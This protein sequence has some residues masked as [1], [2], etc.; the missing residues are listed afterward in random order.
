MD[1][2]NKA[3]PEAKPRLA[4]LSLHG[5]KSIRALENL[6]LGPLNVLIGPNGAGKSNLISFFRF[7]S[8]C[9]N[10]ECQLFIQELGGGGSALLFDGPRSTSAMTAELS[11]ATQSGLNDYQIALAYAEPDTL[12]F[13]SEAYRYSYHGSVAPARWQYFPPGSRE[14][15]IA[16][17]KIAGLPEKSRKTA[18]VIRR[19]LRSCKVYQ[20]HDTSRTS[21]IRQ[22]WSA[23]DS[24][25]LKED[26]ANIAPFLLRLRED[27]PPRYSRIL[28]S[29]RLLAPFV[30]DFVLEERGG[31]VMLQWRE[32]GSDLIFSASQASDGTLRALALIALLSQAPERLP[33]VAVLDE[34]ELGLHPYAIELVAGLVRAAADHCQVILATQSAS[35]VDQFEPEEIVVAERRGRESA[36]SRLDPNALRE[37]LGEYSLSE[38]WEKNVV[39]GR[40]G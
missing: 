3:S 2:G 22:R 37:W 19:C 33:D 18:G 9:M 39:G 1:N 32:K 24:L 23:D 15:Q 10:Q 34:P 11:F 6:A 28:E 12:V 27:D 8:Y 5:F 40:P 38:L 29:F 4:S 21:R 13:T 7:L 20:F 36:F 26:A 35:L 14:A 25:W 30:A 17:T 31:A 16:G